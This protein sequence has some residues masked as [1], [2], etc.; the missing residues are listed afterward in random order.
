[1]RYVTFAETYP[2]A[3]I[4]NLSFTERVNTGSVPAAFL[5]DVVGLG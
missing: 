3:G 5:A 4:I 2:Q 1:V